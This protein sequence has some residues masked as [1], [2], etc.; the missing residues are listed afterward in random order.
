MRTR[1][2]NENLQENGDILNIQKFDN[3][4][5]TANFKVYVYFLSNRFY[6]RLREL[7]DEKTSFDI[8]TNHSD[9]NST[10]T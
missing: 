7:S 1:K 8:S 5:S 4:L 6:P 2:A 9:L 10:I 3:L